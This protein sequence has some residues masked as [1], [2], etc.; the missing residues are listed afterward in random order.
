MEKPTVVQEQFD[1]GFIDSKCVLIA[2]VR[3]IICEF[4][5]LKMLSILSTSDF[6][7]IRLCHHHTFFLTQSCRV[8]FLW[9][10]LIQQIHNCGIYSLFDCLSCTQ[11]RFKWKGCHISWR[12]LNIFQNEMKSQLQNYMLRWHAAFFLTFIVLSF[13]HVRHRFMC[14]HIFLSDE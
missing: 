6:I 12:L 2:N 9:H 4:S 8:I 10:W 11:L 13:P 14:T 7:F 3:P 1:A 5:A